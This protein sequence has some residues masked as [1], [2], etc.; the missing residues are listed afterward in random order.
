MPAAIGPLIE[1]ELNVKTVLTNNDASSL[2]TISFKA[3]FKKLGPRVGR[4][5]KV[6]AQQ[7]SNLEQDA[8]HA[9]TQGETI[10]IGDY[11]I[12]MEDVLVQQ[13]PKNDVVIE[14]LGALSVA[15]DHDLD[16]ALKLEGSAREVVSRL[17]KMRKESGLAITDRIAL[18]VY[19]SDV[20][21]NAA[22]EE[23]ES[24]I[25]DEVLA[26]TLERSSVAIEAFEINIDGAR[27][28]VR[29][30]TVSS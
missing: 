3:N 1:E 25:S 17:Q 20:Q 24:Y 28:D 4:D 15:L 9:L 23:F 10:T 6:V 8:W 13:T 12:D 19:T 27:L 16:E 7:I 2:A 26:S 18:T 30:E 5:M 14:T 21:L 29:M 11:A 22:L